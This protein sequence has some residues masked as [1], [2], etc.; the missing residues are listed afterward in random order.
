M[1]DVGEEL[2]GDLRNRDVVDIDVLLADQ[3]EEQVER[4]VV[5][6]AN[7]DREWRLLALLFL[8]LR[9]CRRW[10]GRLGFGDG[11]GSK[12]QRGSGVDAGLL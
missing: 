5:D 2:C 11:L 1:I 8:L 7:G 10:F 9:L 6:Q 4:A 3:V 12:D